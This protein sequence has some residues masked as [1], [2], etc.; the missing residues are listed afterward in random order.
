M[1]LGNS[2][3][4]IHFQVYIGLSELFG[5]LQ[6]ADKSASYA[7]KAYDLSRSLQP[8]DLNTRHHRNALLQMA[9]SLCKQGEL[10]DA[11]DYCGVSLAVPS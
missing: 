5:R 11:H 4:C 9:S 6:D 2:V 3:N 7:A 8:G 10:G 1:H